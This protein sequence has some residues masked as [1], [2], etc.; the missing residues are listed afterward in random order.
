MEHPDA[1]VRDEFVASAGH[2]VRQL[3][4]RGSKPPDDDAG[5]RQ[6]VNLGHRMTDTLP[7]YLTE[8]IEGFVDELWTLCELRWPEGAAAGSA[9]VRADD[10]DARIDALEKSWRRLRRDLATD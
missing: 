3:R 8:R 1:R 10:L 6:L 7:T 4:H 5:P 2:W 9:A